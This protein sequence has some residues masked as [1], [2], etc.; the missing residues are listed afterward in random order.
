D[1][2]DA[3]LD[4]AADQIATE[5]ANKAAGGVT[6][7]GPKRRAFFVFRK[8]KNPT[9]SRLG[10]YE[11]RLFPKH[12][13]LMYKVRFRAGAGNGSKDSCATNQGWLPNGWYG[14]TFYT[15]YDGIINGLVWHL[16]NK[17]CKKNGTLRTE[18]FIHSEMTPS[19]GQNCGYEPECW[20][21]PQD[22]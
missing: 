7:A 16:D 22:Y 4:A 18:L 15:G 9:K 11:Y 1:N 21:G 12:R 8:A 5:A 17:R 20:N 2:A 13:E 3:A 6:A 10:W 14:G 19:G